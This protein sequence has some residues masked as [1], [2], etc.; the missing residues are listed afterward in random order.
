MI[1]DLFSH[2]IH[3]SGAD[4]EDKLIELA[5]LFSEFDGQVYNRK[6]IEDRLTRI[7][8]RSVYV[9]RDRS[10]FRD[11]YSAYPAYFGL[12]HLRKSEHGWVVQISETTKRCLLR[13]EPD[14]AAFLR[15]QLS[16]FQY[17]NGMGAVYKPGTNHLRLQANTRRRMLGLIKNNIRLSPLRL[18]TR[19]LIADAS[20][21]EMPL[22]KAT[23]SYSEIF[24]LANTQNINSLAS[25]PINDIANSLTKI[26]R[27]E[28]KGPSH[29]ESRFHLLKHLDLF[30]VGKNALG[31]R[32]YVDEDDKK[33]I[34]AKIL[35]IKGISAFFEKFEGV[36]DG[37]ELE[38]L[39]GHGYWPDYFDGVM[40]LPP[41]VVSVLFSDAAIGG[42]TKREQTQIPPPPLPLPTFPLKEREPLLPLPKRSDRVVD[43][44]DPEVTRIKRQR[45]N[46]AHK[47]LL[48]TLDDF[49][50]TKGATPLQNPHIDLYAAI[51]ND[52]SFI[53]EVKS[54]GENLLDQIR[55]GIS[56]LYEYRFRYRENIP[57]EVKL[58]LVLPA[59]PDQIPW[60]SEYL[61]VD[62]GI[63]MC[64]FDNDGRIRVPVHCSEDMAPLVN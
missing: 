9:A 5:F 20:L 63:C 31:F 28:I 30:K 58:C 37:S 43:S 52:G 45:R 26:R 55:K 2:K 15:L 1:T 16:L 7:S 13:E 40:T 25:P 29:F 24:A 54:G 10:K 53:F 38:E 3:S 21:R 11:E 42:S 48:D 33:D 35:A 12:Y 49:L 34:E 4:W 62:R 8:P 36:T 14:V 46:L 22:F 39:I 27:N 51:P 61:C 19:A 17:P 6:K 50:R 32:D 60:L 18:I 64:W 44:A 41:D 23:I 57:K 59:S 56:Q 47:T